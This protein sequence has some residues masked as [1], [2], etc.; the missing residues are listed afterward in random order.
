M[1]Q[2]ALHLALLG[3]LFVIGYQLDALLVALK[4]YAL[5]SFDYWPVVLAAGTLP[6]VMAAL[7]VG[8]AW[9]VLVRQPMTVS[10]GAAYLVIGL[11]VAY[12]VSIL[13]LFP[14]HWVPFDTAPMLSLAL[15]QVSQAGAFSVILALA[16]LAFGRIGGRAERSFRLSAR[17]GAG[18][19]RAAGHSASSPRR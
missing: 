7:E 14:G 19:T 9:W 18:A 11:L 6:L 10:V 8:L 5:Q 4:V 17:A 15:S 16:R 1:R 12:F 2:S 13:K 3:V